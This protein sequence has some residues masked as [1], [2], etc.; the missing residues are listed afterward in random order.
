MLEKPRI[1]A[2]IESLLAPADNFV[3][4]LTDSFKFEIS[5]DY[6]LYNNKHGKVHILSH[7][8]VELLLCG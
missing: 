4:D 7:F 3:E 6:L 2:L 1:C 5:G 8:V